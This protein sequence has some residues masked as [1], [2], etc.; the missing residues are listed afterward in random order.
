MTRRSKDPKKKQGK[1]PKR[2][3]ATPEEI[4]KVLLHTPP[5]KRDEW[6]YLKKRQSA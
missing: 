1:M 6:K 5:R 2:I 4:A 3:D